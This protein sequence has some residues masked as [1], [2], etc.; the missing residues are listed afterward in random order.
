[1]IHCGAID[2]RDYPKF[3]TEPGFLYDQ[4]RA[5]DHYYA[6]LRQERDACLD[7]NSSLN[8]KKKIETRKETSGRLEQEEDLNINNCM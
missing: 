7:S 5:S 6:V 4:G 2:Q 1:M 8:L 3:P